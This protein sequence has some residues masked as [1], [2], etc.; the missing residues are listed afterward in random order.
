[1]RNQLL[2]ITLAGL[3]GRTT[4]FSL[5]IPIIII[6]LIKTQ[7]QSVKL[8]FF[9]GIISDL[10]LGTSLGFYALLFIFF[11]GQLKLL[12]T[13]IPSSNWWTMLLLTFIFSIE[14]QTILG[15]FSLRTVFIQVIL[16]LIFWFSYS[17]FEGRGQIGE[18]FL[19]NS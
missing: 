18:V 5:V 19:K 7:N 11:S 12:S 15:Q 6:L 14:T 16:A 10:L 3:I 17:I 4:T 2:L 1:V 8:A 9:S 13:R